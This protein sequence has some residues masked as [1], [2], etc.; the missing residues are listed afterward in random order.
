VVHPLRDNM[1]EP[2]SS[3]QGT[4]AITYLAGISTISNGVNCAALLHAEWAGQEASIEG[5]ELNPLVIG[6]SAFYVKGALL[7]LVL[8]LL[9][10]MD[11]LY[12]FLLLALFLVLFSSLVSHC[13]SPFFT[14]NLWM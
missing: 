13:A 11:M 14:S 5:K 10:V 9:H 2:A 1:G 6:L 12:F 7:L 8:V 4:Q 3:G